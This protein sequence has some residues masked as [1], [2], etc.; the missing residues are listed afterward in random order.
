MFDA[1]IDRGSE[2]KR[3]RDQDDGNRESGSN[4]FLL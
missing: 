2:V 3:Q 4:D 1:S